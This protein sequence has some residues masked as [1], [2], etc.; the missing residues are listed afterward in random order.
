[1]TVS[2][3]IGAKTSRNGRRLPKGERNRSDQVLNT[4]LIHIPMSPPTVA[5]AAMSV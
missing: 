2:A 3:A 5:K 1:M 4:G